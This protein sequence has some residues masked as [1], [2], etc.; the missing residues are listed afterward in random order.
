MEATHGEL[1]VVFVHGFRSSPSMWDPFR[2]LINEDPDLAFVTPLPFEYATKLVSLHPL[3]RIPSLNEAADSL[4]QFLEEGP[5]ESFQ[6]LALVSHSQGGLVIEHY[7][8]RML[9]EGRGEDLPRISR[10]VL[11]ACPNTGSSIALFLRRLLLPFHPQERQLRPFDPQVA[12]AHRV[13]INQVVM[14]QETTESRCH[15]PI[16]AYA[17]MQD[18]VVTVA[19]ARSVFPNAQPLSGDHSTIVKPDS[20]QHHSYTTVKRHLLLASGESGEPVETLETISAEMLG[21]QNAASP[22]DDPGSPTTFTPYLPRAHDDKLHDVLAPALDGGPSVLAVLTGDASTGKTR[23]LYEVLLDLALTRSLLRPADAEDLLTFIE[24]RRI[25]AGTVLWLNETQQFLDHSAGERAAVRLRALLERQPGV[26]AVGAMWTKPYWSNLVAEGVESDPH[27]Q[28]RAL[29][30]GPRTERIPVKGELES[31]D[32]DRWNDLAQQTGDPRLAHAL[33][34]GSRDGRVVQHLSGGPELLDAYLRSPGDPFTHAEHALISAALD[35]RRLGHRA[36]L[37]AALLSDAAYGALAPHHRSPD[38]AWADHALHALSTGER[39]GGDRI[40]I[41]SPLT[42]LIAGVY[43][44]LGDRAR[45]EPADYLDQHTRPRRA[46]QLGA[47]SLWVALATHTANRDD[48]ARLADAAWRRGLYKQAVQLGRHAV[49]AGH[50]F[51]SSDLIRRLTGT[52]GPHY[53]AAC[54]TAAHADLADPIG[55][56]RLLNALREAGADQAIE[57]LLDRDPAAHADL[58]DPRGIAFLLNALREAGAD[59][60]IEALL[61]RDP[62]SRADLADPFG[63][64]RLLDALQ[65]V[66]ADEAVEAL[67]QREPAAHADLTDPFGIARLL[68]ALRRAGADE[69]VEAL[70][71]REPAAHADLTNPRGVAG[72]LKALRKSSA[73]QA[74]DSVAHRVAAQAD[75]ANPQHVARLLDALRKV[76]AD[77]AVEALLDLDP[78][79]HADLTDLA[80]SRGFAQLLDALREAGADQ[81]VQTLLDRDPAAHAGLR[82]PQHVARLLDALRKADAVQQWALLDRDPAAHADLT[83]PFGVAE[84]LDAL[85]KAD[86]VQQW[87]LLDRDPA[88]HADL[89]NPFGATRL[90]DALRKASAN[91]TI[92][93]VAHRA[94]AQADLTNPHAVAELLHA[95]READADQAIE[96]LLD[97]DPA[98]RAN[99][100]NPRAVA[101]LLNALQKAG[102]HQA[103]DT[104]AHMAADA[105]ALASHILPPYGRETDGRPAT[106]WTWSDIPQ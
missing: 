90:L 61:D 30:T 59:Q 95:L 53:Q 22:G 97:R 52:I 3:R 58:T 70:L 45:Y 67:L 102:A 105:G 19:S 87:A 72:L 50:P 33:K 63:I 49:L 21:I 56:A 27:G 11:F 51:A 92:E 18:K 76:G 69:A 86:A 103:A 40:D 84:L 35:A 16:A 24:E 42:P 100:T 96:T 15:I 6:R 46:D 13:V 93:A 9:S 8:A 1:G 20:H 29:L 44:R 54:W 57:T 7:L 66:G 73:G 98:S 83:N 37:T 43:T 68:D 60:A 91:Q 78:A 101:E 79:A 74:V 4:R 77:E 41:R 89:T 14:A 106:S 28:A 48:L 5:A 62:A 71:Q 23:A 31:G 2:H 36:P 26:V 64:A 12:D 81:A 55:I 82:N 85:R 94:A 25:K 39:V 10:I 32:R 88:A 99:L 104:L 47:P 38:P 17:G 75:L 80:D 65:R 34:A